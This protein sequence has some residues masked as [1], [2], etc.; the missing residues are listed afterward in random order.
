MKAHIS[1]YV[2]I[3]PSVILVRPQMGENI[4]AAARAMMNFGLRDLRIV[5]PRDG[6]PNIKALEMAAHARAIVDQASLFPDVPSAIADLQFVVAATARR[7]D[8]ALSCYS[9]VEMTK[10]VDGIR[11]GWMFGPENNGLSNDDVAFAQAI[12]TIPTDEANASLNIAQ[13]VVVL[14]YQ[15]FVMQRAPSDTAQEDALASVGDV[16]ALF[17]QL[18]RALQQRHFYKTPELQPFMQRQLRAMIARAQ[19]REKEV[20]IVH[21]IIATLTR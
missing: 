21:G 11:A 15:W 17:A 2:M 13:S 18:D 16:E 1:K 14:A 9:P 20:N 4:G 3:S 5:A 10:H 19:L 8:L 6:W 7:R 12:V